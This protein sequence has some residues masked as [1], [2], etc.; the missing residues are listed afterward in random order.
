[1]GGWP[2]VRSPGRLAQ[3]FFPSPWL[4]SC[5]TLYRPAVDAPASSVIKGLVIVTANTS[6]GAGERGV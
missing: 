4:I 6:F 2:C 5:M 3:A 1:M